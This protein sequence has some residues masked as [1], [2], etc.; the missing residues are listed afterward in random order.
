[1]SPKTKI[2]N[3]Q[4]ELSALLKN[5]KKYFLLGLCVFL[6]IFSLPTFK[7]LNKLDNSAKI[8]TPKNKVVDSKVIYE[9]KEGDFLWKIAEDYYGSGFNAYDIAIYNKLQEPYSLVTGNKLI[10]PH[11]TPKEATKGEISATS[12]GQVKYFSQT[13]IIQ[14]GDDLCQ[15]AIRFYGDCNNAYRIIQANNILNPDLVEV[16]TILQIP[17]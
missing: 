10:L 15:I 3:Y 1:M 5:K 17:R 2:V 7:L 14:P 16:G 4:I 12:S 6:A 9:V 8:K 13:Y 11:V